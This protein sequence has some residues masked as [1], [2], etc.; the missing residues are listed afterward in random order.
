M[1]G[2]GRWIAPVFIERLWCSVTYEEVYCTAMQ[3]LA[4][5]ENPSQTRYGIPCTKAHPVGD[6][7]L[8]ALTS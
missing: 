6:L 5:I 2:K 1:D 4:L 3:Q 8:K 7:Q